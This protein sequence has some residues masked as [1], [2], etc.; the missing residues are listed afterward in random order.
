MG[1]P[2]TPAR[3][4]PSVT[5]ARCQHKVKV[6]T[7]TTQKAMAQRAFATRGVTQ[8]LKV[9]TRPRQAATGTAGTWFQLDS[10][11]Q[12]ERHKGSCGLGDTAAT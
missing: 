3:P 12:A 11:R 9:L 6:C 7:G 5:N 1:V 4:H 10:Q 2:P 8:A